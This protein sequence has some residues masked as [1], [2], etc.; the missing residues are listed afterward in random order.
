M[1]TGY[2]E[3]SVQRSNLNGAVNWSNAISSATSGIPVTAFSSTL[4]DIL[5][6]SLTL[7][8]NQI[9]EIAQ[10][11]TID[12]L[13][14]ALSAWDVSDINKELQNVET[15]LNTLNN[16]IFEPIQFPNVLLASYA[17]AISPDARKEISEMLADAE[18]ATDR[19]LY[20][21]LPS[22]EERTKKILFNY[23]K[24]LRVSLQRVLKCRQVYFDN[25]LLLS[26]LY[27]AT[28]PIENQINKLYKTIWDLLK[29]LNPAV[30]RVNKRL[31]EINQLITTLNQLLAIPVLSSTWTVFA[32]VGGANAYYKLTFP[33]RAFSYPGT[34]IDGKFEIGNLTIH[35]FPTP[36]G[37]AVHHLTQRF[38]LP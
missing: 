5:S 32:D 26:G 1:I 2:Q 17:V 33:G 16:Q 8:T 37:G 28:F 4:M 24:D 7:G 31:I 12:E 29:Q 38:G 13:N 3:I 6:I 18:T 10:S 9:S 21:V 22:I 35:N 23:L 11:K 19:L 27:S 25:L 30:E 20:V 14:N 15:L 36:G 34:E